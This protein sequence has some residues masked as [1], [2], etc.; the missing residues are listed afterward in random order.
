MTG[1]DN[2]DVR[3]WASQYDYEDL[4][5]GRPARDRGHFTLLELYRIARW[6]SPRRAELLNPTSCEPALSPFAEKL[7]QFVLELGTHLDESAYEVALLDALPGVGIPTASAILTV[8]DPEQ[9]GIIDVRTWKGLHLLDP[10]GPFSMRVPV[11]TP[12]HYRSYLRMLRQLSQRH[13]CHCR[14][15]D[16]ALYAWNRRRSSLTGG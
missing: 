7:T 16:C 10:Q 6:K 2:F 8:A 14:T 3:Y 11:F 1:L 12:V 15:V 4:P 13:A 5:D 9:Y